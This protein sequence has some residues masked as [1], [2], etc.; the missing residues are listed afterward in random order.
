MQQ[1]KRISR[2]MK[3]EL[4]NALGLQQGDEKWSQWRV[5]SRVREQPLP[6]TQR[7]Q[8]RAYARTSK[9]SKLESPVEFDEARKGATMLIVV[10]TVVIV[11]TT[12]S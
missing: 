11:L 2:I 9:K 12:H 10:E 6:K 7:S 3:R 4:Q 1:R 5:A 8:N